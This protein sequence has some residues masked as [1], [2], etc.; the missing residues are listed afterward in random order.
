MTQHDALHE[1]CQSQQTDE[2][3]R[4]AERPRVVR[5]HRPEPGLRFF[6]RLEFID[7]RINILQAGRVRRPE[8]PPARELRD[9]CQRRFIEIRRRVDV[10]APA[11]QR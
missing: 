5:L 6:N 10:A 9:L 8:I 4:G 1:P 7:E 11:N 3:E 2:R